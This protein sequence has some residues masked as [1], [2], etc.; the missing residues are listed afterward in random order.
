MFQCPLVNAAPR[1]PKRE[2][3]AFRERKM[4]KSVEEAFHEKPRKRGQNQREDPRF[5]AGYSQI[6]KDKD[7]NCERK[8]YQNDQYHETESPENDC[9]RSLPS[10]D[11]FNCIGELEIHRVTLALFLAAPDTQ[12]RFHQGEKKNRNCNCPREKRRPERPAP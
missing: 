6:S 5:A 1:L 3:P 8:T 10:Q 11:W 2:Y 7:W 9:H 12:G 4:E